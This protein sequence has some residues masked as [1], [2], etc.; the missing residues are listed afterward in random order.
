MKENQMKIGNDKKSKVIGILSNSIL[1]LSNREFLT[2]FFMYLP[3]CRIPSEVCK[4]GGEPAVNLVQ[5]QLT[6]GRFNHGLNIGE[7]CYE[8]LFLL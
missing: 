1:W 4:S 8:S 6:L 7:C 5:S 2:M 3:T